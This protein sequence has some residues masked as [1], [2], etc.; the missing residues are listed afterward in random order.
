MIALIPF[1]HNEYVLLIT[2]ILITLASFVYK[3]ERHD[4]LAYGIGLVALTISEY[5]FIHTKVETFTQTGLLGV[6]P[7]WLPFLWAYA[8]VAIK[9]SLKV[10]D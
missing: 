1:L 10:L 7:I 5:F 4:Y 8:F 9:R 2:Y 3:R 6:M